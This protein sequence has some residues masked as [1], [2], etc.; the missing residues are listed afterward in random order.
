M[1]NT[2]NADK[3]QRQSSTNQQDHKTKMTK[4]KK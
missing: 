1:N 3:K 2:L 4:A